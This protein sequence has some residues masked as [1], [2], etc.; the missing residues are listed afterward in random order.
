MSRRESKFNEQIFDLSQSHLPRNK[1]GP[2]LRFRETTFPAASGMKYFASHVRGFRKLC[3][4]FWRG[5]FCR[6]RSRRF[7][8]ITLSWQL[9][10]CSAWLAL[11]LRCKC[12]V[13]N[14]RWFLACA[15]CIVSQVKMWQWRTLISLLTSPQADIKTQRWKNNCPILKKCKKMCWC[16]SSSKL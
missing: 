15:I 7:P 6:G 14:T 11:V 10:V 1:A 9:L 12:L 2:L 8:I 13:A 4:S 16:C 3:S 5:A